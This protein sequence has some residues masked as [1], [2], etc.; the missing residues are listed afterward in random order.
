MYQNLLRCD[1]MTVEE[2]KAWMVGTRINALF[3]LD[4][5]T[6]T[7]EFITALPRTDIQQFRYNSLCYKVN[8]ELFLFPDRGDRIL[9]F[10]LDSKEFSEIEITN[11]NAER[12]SILN[13]FLIGNQI[14]AVARGLKQ[15]LTVNIDEKKIDEIYSMEQLIGASYLSD[16]MC[17]VDSQ[18]YFTIPEENVICEF[19][20]ETKK[21]NKYILSEKIMPYTICYV[22]DCFV[23]TGRKK[24][25]YSWDKC[26]NNLNIIAEFPSKIKLI[27]SENK[28]QD[29]SIDAELYEHAFFRWSICRGKE[30]WF[31]PYCANNILYIN[32]ENDTIG[33]VDIP[34]E[35]ENE[36]TLQ[37]LE[38]IKYRY[39]GM[40]F[41]RYLCLYSFKNKN[42][43]LIDL[44]EHT[45]CI[46]TYN[47]S[48]DSLKEVLGRMEIIIESE[49]VD[50]RDYIAII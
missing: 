18:I 43:L 27:E 32:V 44:E 13:A 28:E 34:C 15:I 16:E 19:I 20:I 8:N 14:Y 45:Y 21:L 11:P 26:S 7:Y 31:I 9:I 25:I 10:N 41:E 38:K 6:K 36:K 12:I 2:N 24:G 33:I 4:F 5:V 22:N 50:I 1:F 37:R 46:E 3:E 47:T 48:K 49:D 42:Y 23:V 39:T 29:G 35:E 40:F 17:M 30:L